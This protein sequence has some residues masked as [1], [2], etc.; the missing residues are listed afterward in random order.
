M[1]KMVK[2]AARVGR[3]RRLETELLELSAPY[4]TASYLLMERISPYLGPRTLSLSFKVESAASKT[5][6]GLQINE[7]L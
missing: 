1:Y 4:P 2:A 6:P 7:S 5:R 3:C